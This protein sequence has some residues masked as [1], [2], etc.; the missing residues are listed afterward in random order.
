MIVYMR[1]RWGQAWQRYRH[2]RKQ[3]RASC[4]QPD[5]TRNNPSSSR[6]KW[7][8]SS[9]S[10]SN[11]VERSTLNVDCTEKDWSRPI[12]SMS[13][14][15]MAVPEGYP[16][17]TLQTARSPPSNLATTARME[18]RPKVKTVAEQIH[19]TQDDDHHS[20]LETQ[21]D[22][23]DDDELYEND[24]QTNEPEYITTS[25]LPT[26]RDDSWSGSFTVGSRCEI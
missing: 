12:S 10:D 4:S 11:K 1:R 17:D 16:D 7:D 2:R 24:S 26:I 6:V 9:T 3:E 13:D 8:P 25:T 15:G 21:D 19:N 18:L 14:D 22:D 5:D 20:I 23:D